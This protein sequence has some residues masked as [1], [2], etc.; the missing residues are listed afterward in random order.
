MGLENVPASSEGSRASLPASA[1]FPAVSLV[2]PVR[3]EEKS[4]PLLIES[5]R[6]QL[7]SPAEIIIVDGGSTDETVRLAA[8]LTEGDEKFR[9][10]EAGAATP[11][12]GR[13]VGTATARCEWVAYTDAG[14]RLEPNWLER[15]V[16]EVRRDPSVE[17]VYGDFEPVT[18]TF[19]ERCAALA[20]VP[21][22][23]AGPERNMR[24]PFIAS[25][26]LRRD[27]WQRVGG[28]PDLRAAE[29]L[30]FME[31][32]ETAGSRIAWARE[33]T[34]HWQLQPTLARTFKK[35]ILYSRHNV[36]AGRQRYWHYG[37]ARQYAMA[38]PFIILAL[39]HSPWW[40][41]VPALGLIFRALKSIW[42]R[43]EARGLL[44]LLNPAQLLSVLL[45]ILTIDLATFIGWA[46]ALWQQ[47]RAPQEAQGL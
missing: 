44:W 3:N 37:I 2:I 45:I 14:I 23:Q 13:N 38:L 20:Y 19:F 7:F 4:L 47:P 29:D 33:A 31:Q 35:F 1:P 25:S 42:R 41:I 18:E 12:R 40:L 11:G 32:I 30:M 9:V 16:A 5:I 24:G 39:I 46:Q 15:L 10:I 34:V 6:E 28:F 21:P 27:V 43:R 26:L 8:S 17:V 36:W 22:R